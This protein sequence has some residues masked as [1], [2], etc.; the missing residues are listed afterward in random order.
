MAMR[1][2]IVSTDAARAGALFLWETRRLSGVGIR[3]SYG[4]NDDLVHRWAPQNFSNFLARH[5][6]YHLLGNLGLAQQARVIDDLLGRQATYELFC[7]PHI[8]MERCP[9]L[10]VYSAAYQ[11]SKHDGDSP[12]ANIS[13]V[14]VSNLRRTLL[15]VTS[16]FFDS[17]SSTVGEQ[18]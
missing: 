10:S 1:S 5:E 3:S 13:N 2:A 7:P 12:R 4:Q 8:L 18:P 16:S 6:A 9:D 17:P 15:F 14:H 11:S